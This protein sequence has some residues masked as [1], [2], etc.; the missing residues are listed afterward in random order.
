[1][2][3]YFYQEKNITIIYHTLF[4]Y[5]KQI[6]SIL[7]SP[8]GEF[9]NRLNDSISPRTVLSL[10]DSRKSL[11]EEIS[12][13]FIDINNRSNSIKDYHN[14]LENGG[15]RIDVYQLHCLRILTEIDPPVYC[16]INNILRNCVFDQNHDKEEIKRWSNII[17]SLQST[18]D[19]IPGFQEDVKVYKPQNSIPSNIL[20]IKIG[21]EIIWPTFNFCCLNQTSCEILSSGKLMYYFILP[22][23]TGAYFPSISQLPFEQMILLPMFSKFKVLNISKTSQIQW[24][25]ELSSPQFLK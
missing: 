7:C 18:I 16:T 21:S 2:E 12:S 23:N 19:C 15:I 8:I 24:L 10:E 4:T 5:G 25:I 6:M 22:K 17:K 20:D 13:H 3:D 9:I 11:I 1:M 14:Y